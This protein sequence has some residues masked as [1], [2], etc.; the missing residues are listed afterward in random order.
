[1]D[2]TELKSI[3]GILGVIEDTM[4]DKLNAYGIS[5]HVTGVNEGCDEI[6]ILN[7]NEKEIAQYRVQIEKI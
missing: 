7:E 6:V 4:Q 1:M 5:I 3:S 2:L